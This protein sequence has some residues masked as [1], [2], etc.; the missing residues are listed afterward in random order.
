MSLNRLVDR[1]SSRP[2][3]QEKIRPLFCLFLING[4][5]L[6]FAHARGYDPYQI[7]SLSDQSSIQIEVKNFGSVERAFKFGPQ[8]GELIERQIKAYGAHRYQI[9]CLKRN[10]V[11]ATPQ[12]KFFLGET[13]DKENAEFHD[14]VARSED[15]KKVIWNT[16]SLQNNNQMKWS[17][18]KTLNQLFKRPIRTVRVDTFI[19]QMSAWTRAEIFLTSLKALGDL[20]ENQISILK[21]MVSS[22]MTLV[23]GTGDMEGDE[24][25][26]QRFSPVSLGKVMTTSGAL[27]EQ[28]PRVSSYRRLFPRGEAQP[29]MIADGETIATESQLG[30]GRVRVLAVRLNEITSGEAATQLLSSDW[31]AR[32]QLEEWLDLTMPPLTESPRL[33]SDSVWYLLLL[34]PFMF[35]YSAGRWR[36]ILM[37]AILWQIANIVYPPLFASTSIRRAHMLYIP[38]DEGAVILAQVDLN[39]F[40]RGGRAEKVSASQLALISSETAGACLIHNLAQLNASVDSSEKAS[41][42]NQDEENKGNTWWVI[43]SDLGKRQRFKYIA[44]ASK[45]PRSHLNIEDEV[46]SEW[47]PGPWSGATIEALAPIQADLP[48]AAD[49][50][51]VKAW[52]IPLKV[53]HPMITPIEFRQRINKEQE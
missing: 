34:I 51:G 14:W 27:L 30:L 40:D 33:L 50:G 42:L 9:Q 21:M 1:G 6:N 43:D 12:L 25:L 39:S 32:K 49:L 5:L 52:R 44:Y 19:S 13:E 35:W 48:I 31:R 18:R 47:P 26:I 38:M 36:Y 22:G 24:R 53:P 11:Q 20:S 15:P 45:I 16:G 8:N 29:M 46:L 4:C 41:V 17:L 7:S 37:S 28:L 2:W 10:D 3:I 23:I